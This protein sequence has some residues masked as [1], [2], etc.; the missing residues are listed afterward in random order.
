MPTNHRILRTDSEQARLESTTPLHSPPR[1][2]GDFEL[3]AYPRIIR[4][5]GIDISLPAEP[6]TRIEPS[7]EP[8]FVFRHLVF[9]SRLNLLLILAPFAALGSFFRWNAAAVFL[10][11]LFSI[12]PLAERL[13]YITEQLALHTNET[14]G[15]LLNATFGNATEMIISFFALLKGVPSSGDNSLYYRRL[16]QVSLLGSVISNLLLVFGSSLL[17]GGCRYHIQ[18]FNQHGGR[19]SV[20]LFLVATTAVVSP[21]VIDVSI[22][23][24]AAESSILAFSRFASV[25]LFALYLVF[26]NFQ[27]RSHRMLFEENSGFYRMRKSSLSVDETEDTSVEDTN[28]GEEQLIIG[29]NG[30]L[31]ALAVVSILISFLSSYLVNAVEGA[32]KLLELPEEF[33]GAVLIPIVGNAAEHTSAVYMAYKN[34]MDVAV[35]I[36]VGSAVQISVSVL[37]CCILIGWVIGAPIDLKF[38]RFEVFAFIISVISAG[39]SISGGSSNYLQGVVLI[40]IY[41]FLSMGFWLFN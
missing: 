30:S 10:L 38:E 21:L 2:G 41:L 29:W 23:E 11:S 27:L 31:V 33:V 13:G 1:S 7:D 40:S 22:S 24:Q 32:A 3:A 20:T 17:I 4:T 18:Y 16:V 26:L 14:I 8:M 9:S 5:E 19:A 34:K 15:G 25:V 6:T 36:A 12:A 37:P 39:Y 28:D 35:G